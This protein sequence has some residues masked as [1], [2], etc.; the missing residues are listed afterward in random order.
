MF[1]WIL[2]ALLS[3]L[4]A[5]LAFLPLGWVA[6]AAV[7]DNIKTLAPDLAYHGTVWRG[8]VSG[9]PIFG[10][11][12]LEIKPLS[13][14]AVIQSGQSQNYVS[15]DI[16]PSTAKDMDLRINLA[17]LPF[18]DGR[19]QGLRGTLNAQISNM[20]IE[21]QSCASAAGTAK[22][23][24]LQRNGGTIQWTGPE[25]VGPIRCEQGALI[26]DLNGQDA[27]QKISALIRMSPDNTYR[28][29]ITVRTTRAEA[30][31]VLPI[32]GFSRSG[33]NFILVEQGRWR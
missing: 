9:L 29:D 8:T 33:Q 11:A 18:T 1:R 13:R 14:R 7:P 31:A 26:A 6:G 15:A 19:L 10:T 16:G 25:L 4:F 28:V 32:F 5:V 21:N 20:E 24:V 17:T 3:G 22:T 27:Q 30:D 23:D 2:P 12:N